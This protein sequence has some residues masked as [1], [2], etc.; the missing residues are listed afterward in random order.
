MLLS[1][2]LLPL[3]LPA[4]LPKATSSFHL[5][6]K[7]LESRQ[8]SDDLS[9]RQAWLI[10]QAK[11]MRAKY[12]PYLNERGRELLKRDRMEK[13]EG[14]M[15]RE[16]TTMDLMDIGLDGLYCAPIEIGTPPQQFIVIMDTGSSDLWVAERGCAAEFCSKTYTFDASSS[17]TFESKRKQ[18]NISYGSGNAGGYLAND[19]VSAGGFTIPDQAFAVVTQAANGLIEYP[20]SGLLGLA[21]DTIASTYS[22]PFWQA[23]AS[24]GTWDSPEMGVYLARFKGNS[25]ARKIEF[26]GGHFNFGGVDSTKFEG[27]LNYIP[28]GQGDRNFWKLPLEGMTIG[29]KPVDV[30]KGLLSSN[31][32][33]CAIDTGTTLIGVPT[34]MAAAIYAQI[35]GSSKVPTLVIGQEG[36]YQYPCDTVV[37]V[38]LK[39][40]G[41]EYGISNMDMNFGT[42]TDDGKICIGSFFAIDVSSKSPIQWIIGAAF[43][44]NVYTSFR[45]EPT[46]IGFAPLTSN[47]TLLH[48]KR[49]H[50]ISGETIMNGTTSSSSDG[51]QS[52]GS[53]GM[54]QRHVLWSMLGL[55]VML[56]HM[57][58]L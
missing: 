38:K 39:F 47:A 14:Q 29:E 7:V 10:S 13:K 37:N 43:L 44:K 51:V 45:Y 26:D 53:I 58:A 52:T 50:I 12:E 5:P 28:I 55:G 46:A 15:K 49:M 41:V 22:V 25:S 40:G 34:D 19:I 9:Q 31:S 4:M 56:G 48:S 36:Y 54:Q 57:M 21:W 30:S 1:L 18:F 16:Q 32:P 3:T 20:V 6:L 33:S 42:F 27:D 11:S 17:S 2:T 23:L 8:H 24:S 35:P